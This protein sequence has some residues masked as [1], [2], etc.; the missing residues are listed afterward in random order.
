MQLDKIPKAGTTITRKRFW[1]KARDTIVSLQ[2]KA[3]RNVSVD[4]RKGLG[5]VINIPDDNRGRGGG[6]CCTISSIRLQVHLTGCVHKLVTGDCACLT[7]DCSYDHTWNCPSDFNCDPCSENQTL[8]LND[9]D[10]SGCIS[11]VDGGTP[12]G[13]TDFTVNLFPF[14]GPPSIEVCVDPSFNCNPPNCGITTGGGNFC[15]I[16]DWMSETC[17]VGTYN[18]AD[19]FHT[20]G[21]DLSYE[22]TLTVT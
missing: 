8:T 16:D 15:V 19:E 1:D 13:S 2:K 12:T 3:G 9:Q 14:S 5:T 17:P 4:E 6:G 21:F 7:F 20:S 10:N 22:I 11:C 18:W